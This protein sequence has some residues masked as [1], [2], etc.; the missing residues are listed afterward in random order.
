MT[1][2]AIHVKKNTTVT[3]PSGVSPGDVIHVRAP[4]GRLNAITVP[5]GMGPGSTFTVEFAEDLP[6]PPE[7]DLA[8]G[9]YVPT[10]TAQPEEIGVGT[11]TAT[12][13][14]GEVV[15]S[16]TTGPYVPAYK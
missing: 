15:A 5:D 3:L 2:I 9:V 8:P 7:A 6:P 12:V 1:I 13:E 16:A 10:V 4:D 14:G 11:G